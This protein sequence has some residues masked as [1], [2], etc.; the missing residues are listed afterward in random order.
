MTTNGGINWGY[1]LPDTHYINILEYS[2]IHFFNT[3]HGWAYWALGKG[4]HTT[5]GGD[6]TIYVGINN[7]NEILPE[8]YTLEQ[9]YPN[10]FNQSSII[11]YKCSINGIINIAVYD[12]T[13]KKIAV[14]VNEYKPAGIYSVNFNSDELPSGVYFYSLL[15]NG[16]I[17]DT[18]KAIYLK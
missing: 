1:Q 18:K 17:A 9:N 8:E 10:P 12:L 11:N 16:K 6:S 4:V 2:K 3:K 14:L 15:V 7:Q 5:T 13:G